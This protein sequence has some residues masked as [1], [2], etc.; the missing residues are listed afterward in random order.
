M[1]LRELLEA[2]KAPTV[3]VFKQ[4]ELAG[5]IERTKTGAVFRYTERYLDTRSTTHGIA[6]NFPLPHQGAHHE[7]FVVHGDNVHPFF[8]G[9][10]PEGVRFDALARSVKTSKDDLLTLLVA[11]GPDA[12]GDISVYPEPT[13]PDSF[14][15]V[16]EVAALPE[17][18]FEELWKKSIGYATDAARDH[19][20]VAGV[21]RKISASRLTLPVRKTQTSGHYIL[22]LPSEAYPCLVDNELF[23]MQ[24][25]RAC[26]LKTAN[27]EIATDR[28]GQRALL[29][30][31]FDRL[32][33]RDGD[34]KVHQEDACQFLD[35]Y[36]ADKYLLSLEQVATGLSFCRAPIVATHEVLRLYAF[37]YLVGNGDLHG[38]NISLRTDP[39]TDAVEPTPAYDLLSTLPYGDEH[40]AL[41]IE[42]KKARLKARTFIDFAT[43]F[44]IPEKATRK[45]LRDL[46]DAARPFA[47]N[48]GQIGLPDKQTEDL[49]HAMLERCSALSI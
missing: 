45:L 15:S 49:Q 22:K 32:R 16:P 44:S 10:L 40:M 2:A 42:G 8:A 12:I 4:R 14:A 24:M 38:K 48:V 23:F 5:T 9:L 35:R 3:Y 17:T 43:R 7:G 39:K 28:D 34:I 31:R 21:Q 33:T 1:N 41:S 20:P 6:Y 37:S 29:V 46:C 27:V 11:A 19:K 25:A 30:E 36:P 18:S 47:E 26:G 13:L